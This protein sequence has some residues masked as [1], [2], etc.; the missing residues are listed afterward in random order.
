VRQYKPQLMDTVGKATTVNVTPAPVFK[1][2]GK[3]SPK[4]K[5]TDKS[6]I[7][8]LNLWPCV[9]DREVFLEP[10]NVLRSH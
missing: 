9:S 8:C 6:V 2:E 3:Y 10:K 4:G 5:S 1:Q 7:F